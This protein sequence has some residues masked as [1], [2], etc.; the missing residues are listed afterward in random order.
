MDTL[1]TTRSVDEFRRGLV[2]LYGENTDWGLAR[3]AAADFGML[4]RS[5]YRYLE[6]KR[7]VQSQSWAML[8]RLLRH[9]RGGRPH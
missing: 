8:D 1:L 6:R 5:L 2:E 4:A 7:E 9:H 3:R